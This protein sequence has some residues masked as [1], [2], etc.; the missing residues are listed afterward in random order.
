MGSEEKRFRHGDAAEKLRRNKTASRLINAATILGLLL[1]VGFAVYGFY[2]GIFTSEENLE[3]FISDSG[4]TAPLVFIFI[5]IIQVVVPIIPGG[6]SCLASVVLFGPLPGF[7]YSDAGICIGSTIGFFLGRFYGKPFILA[8]TKPETYEKY[9]KIIDKGKR[10]EVFF[11]LAMLFPAFPDDLICMLAGLTKMESK[12]F[13]L[14]LLLAKIP[15]I[16]LYS[17]VRASA[18]D[19]FW[20]LFA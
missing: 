16:A 15:A 3:R 17:L 10:F 4:V 5:Q 13:L 1:A 9:S 20:R 19:S 18:E 11:L 8:V 12:K 6:V 7:V 14:I 2:T